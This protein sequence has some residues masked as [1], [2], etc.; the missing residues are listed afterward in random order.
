VEALGLHAVSPPHTS[1]TFGIWDGVRLVFK[2][3][4]FKP[5][6]FLKMLWRCARRCIQ[7]NSHRDCCVGPCVAQRRHPCPP[8]VAAGRYHE[9]LFKL[10]GVVRRS[11]EAFMGIYAL[12]QECQAFDS[13]QALWEALGLFN[14]TQVGTTRTH[15]HAH[16]ILVMNHETPPPEMYH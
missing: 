4:E 12:Q 15:T 5:W 11:L 2:T 3:S 10:Y 16:L 7:A 8:Y 9:G 1:G 6:T 13:P 14:L